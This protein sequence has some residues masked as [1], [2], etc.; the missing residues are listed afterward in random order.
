MS[1]QSGICDDQAKF[2]DEIIDCLRPSGHPGMH[3]GAGDRWWSPGMGIKQRPPMPLLTLVERLDR[4]A[5]Q[6][7]LPTIVVADALRAIADEQE[8]WTSDQLHHL[9]E[10]IEELEKP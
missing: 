6:A 5:S 2:D 1:E 9:A 8:A 10:E 7:D 3:Q 4:I